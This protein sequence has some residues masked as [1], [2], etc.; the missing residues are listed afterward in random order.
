[1]IKEFDEWYKT[2]SKADCKNF[3]KAYYDIIKADIAKVEFN[4]N[5]KSH[6]ELLEDTL[7]L[8]N[9]AENSP[10]GLASDIQDQIDRNDVCLEG[11]SNILQHAKLVVA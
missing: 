5:L 3:V 9:I 7:R 4:S 2:L 8:H 11:L 10:P 1:M 6:S